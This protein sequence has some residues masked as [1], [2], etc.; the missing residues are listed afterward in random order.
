MEIS[1]SVVI[2]RGFRFD[3][4]VHVSV[5]AFPSQARAWSSMPVHLL[6]IARHRHLQY[7]K[8]C[9]N[10]CASQILSIFLSTDL[11]L[12]STCAHKSRRLFTPTG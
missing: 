11:L 9:L 4:R 10:I 3:T 12:E 6:L 5:E 2:L 8:V 1:Y 7:S